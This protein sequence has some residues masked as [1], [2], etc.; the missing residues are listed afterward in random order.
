MPNFGFEAKVMWMLMPMSRHFIVDI[1][2]DVDAKAKT[3]K[4]KADSGIDPKTQK[5][6]GDVEGKGIHMPKF[7][8]GGKGKCDVDVNIDANAPKVKANVD[9]Y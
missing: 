6:K 1:D 5:V 3:P 9:L 7:E 8:F 4:V 2:I